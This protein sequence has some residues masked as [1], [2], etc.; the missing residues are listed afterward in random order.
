MPRR[1]ASAPRSL[2]RPRSGQPD[3]IERCAE[4][5]QQGVTQAA[6]R[7]DVSAAASAVWAGEPDA[8]NALRR[9]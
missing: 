5:A 3:L 8:G 4:L 9:K 7:Y 1:L 2:R 6:S